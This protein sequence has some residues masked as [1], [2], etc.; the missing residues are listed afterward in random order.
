MEP[1]AAAAAGGDVES[2]AMA[3]EIKW[4]IRPG[5]EE[6]TVTDDGLSIGASGGDDDD[7]DHDEGDDDKE[8]STL[9][10]QGPRQR[11]DG[12]HAAEQD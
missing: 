12:M 4:Y 6:S 11:Y 5:E 3:D 2:I 10:K 1:L 8:D 7:D 9:D